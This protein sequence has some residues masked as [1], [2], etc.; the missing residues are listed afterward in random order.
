MKG[1]IGN[2][3]KQAQKMQEELQKAQ[4]KLAEEEVTGEAGGGLVK[5]TMNGKHEVRKVDIDDSLLGDDKEML[6][7]LIASACNDAARRVAEKSEQSMSG[8]TSGLNLPP[9][10]KLPF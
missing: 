2:I 8:L 6:E 4:E 9:G 10:M 5:V 1:G 7:D 3:M